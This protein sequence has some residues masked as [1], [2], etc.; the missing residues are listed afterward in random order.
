M[1]QKVLGHSEPILYCRCAVW[2]YL[3]DR[4]GGRMLPD[5]AMEQKRR[6]QARHAGA[7]ASVHMEDERQG[8]NHIPDQHGTHLTCAFVDRTSA[9][10]W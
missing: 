5:A 9:Y 2:L 8:R 10:L 1:L 7:N 4:A 3:A 6:E